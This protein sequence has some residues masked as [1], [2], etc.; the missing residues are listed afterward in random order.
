MA[1][2]KIRTKNNLSGI[3]SPTLKIF[4]SGGSDVAEN[5]SGSGD[6][7][8]AVTNRLGEYEV[9]IDE[10]LSG[11]Y[12]CEISSGSILVAD[13]WIYLQDDTDTYY[14]HETFAEA[15]LYKQ[16]LAVDTETITHTGN[17]ASTVLD[18]TIVNGY[19]VSEILQLIGS[20][21]GGDI[22]VTDN[23]N[24][25]FTLSLK[26]LGDNAT[27]RISALCTAA[28]ARTVTIRSMD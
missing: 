3:A 18:E 14:V 22:E 4:A 23:L 28:G 9:T 19:S 24:D 12:P 21:F 26:D 25:T 13:G 11:F 1:D 15:M 27:E 17:V 8:S 16:M 10:A 20:T 5:N 2:T 6:V 7:F